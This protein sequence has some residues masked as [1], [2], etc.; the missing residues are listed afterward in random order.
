MVARAPEWSNLKLHCLLCPEKSFIPWVFYIFLSCC[1]ISMRWPQPGEGV[2]TD[3]RWNKSQLRNSRWIHIFSAHWAMWDWPPTLLA[4]GSCSDF[5]PSCDSKISILGT[6]VQGGDSYQFY[7]FNH[8]LK[9]FEFVSI[10]GFCFM[11]LSLCLPRQRR[12]LEVVTF[13]VIELSPE[14]S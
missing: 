5:L 7:I 11:I 13:M 1:D 3:S 9:S 2:A 8:F 4:A 12:A 14:V 6:K 10:W